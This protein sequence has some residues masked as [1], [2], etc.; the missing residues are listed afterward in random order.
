MNVPKRALM[1]G[2]PALSPQD[3]HA[4]SCLKHGHKR[5]AYVP[6]AHE[7]LPSCTATCPYQAVGHVFHVY[8]QQKCLFEALCSVLLPIA[9]YAANALQLGL[10]RSPGVFDELHSI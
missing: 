8:T 3:H 6:F 2:E 9:T 4:R 1:A 5:H 10:S 7:H